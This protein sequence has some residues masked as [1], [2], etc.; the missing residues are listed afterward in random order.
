MK[1]SCPLPLRNFPNLLLFSSTKYFLSHL[2][3]RLSTARP[4]RPILFLFGE[5]ES[6]GGFPGDRC[7]RLPPGGRRRCVE[8]ASLNRVGPLWSSPESWWR[9]QPRW[10]IGGG[11]RHGAGRTANSTAGHC[12]VCPAPSARG[13]SRRSASGRIHQG[14]P[15]LPKLLRVW[16]FPSRGGSRRGGGFW[17]PLS[18]AA[19]SGACPRLH[20]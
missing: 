18:G 5:Q 19:N 7:I 8:G 13:A 16:F 1:R 2:H 15:L 3:L 9:R 10:G 12:C 17:R 6:G 20:S 4:T 11:A 14:P